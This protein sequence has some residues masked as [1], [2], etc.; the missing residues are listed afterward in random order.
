MSPHRIG[1]QVLVVGILAL[2]LVGV[3]S[4]I[5]PEATPDRLHEPTT[6]DTNHTSGSTASGPG[7]SVQSDSNTPNQVFETTFTADSDDVPNDLLRTQDGNYV[8][9]GASSKADDSFDAGITKV[10]PSGEIIWSNVIENSNNQSF[11][12]GTQTSDG[13]FII[14]GYTEQN[15]AAGWLVKLDSNGER[16]WTN[17]FTYGDGGALNDAVETESGEYLFAGEYEASDGTDDAEVVKTTSDGTI[18]WNFSYAHYDYDA[19]QDFFGIAAGQDDTYYLAGEEYNDGNW[20]ALAVQINSVG[21]ELSSRTYGH[22]NLDDWFTDVTVDS[23]GDPYY[24]GFRNGIYDESA[25]VYNF[26]DAWVYHDGFGDWSQTVSTDDGNIFDSINAHNGSVVAS[27]WATQTDSDTSDGI[28]ASYDLVGTEQWQLTTTD[29]YSQGLEAT[30]ATDSGAYFTEIIIA[31]DGAPENIRFS[32]YTSQPLLSAS[33]SATNAERA[34]ETN[35]TVSVTN[36]STGLPVEGASVR[37][38]QLGIAA[39]TNESGI[40]SLEVDQDT[41]GNYSI[42]INHPDYYDTAAEL[43]VIEPTPVEIRN[44]DFSGGPV[45]NESDNYTLSFDVAN[46]SA[47]GDPDEFTVTLP[48]SVDLE[49]V[50]SVTA[51]DSNRQPSYGTI[52]NRITFDVNRTGEPENQHLSLEV[53][54]RLSPSE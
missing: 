22:D 50:D 52:D 48:E 7:I 20:D 41:A 51:T 33:L 34:T 8:F 29:S 6:T 35:L 47:D 3:A 5:P 13:G 26:G 24:S 18:K 11:Y 30:V 27:G 21:E 44:V 39:T 45:T 42:Q 9:M 43:R 14:A 16:E 37:N 36:S 12:G 2:S 28:A 23:D 19:S 25:E 49:G 1:F 4:A 17:A 54:L 53:D 32:E 46:I 40:A 10:T 31:S 15:T 38:D